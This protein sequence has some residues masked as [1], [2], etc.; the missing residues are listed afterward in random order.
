MQGRPQP[1]F[2]TQ[3]P[4]HNSNHN[5][6]STLFPPQS[7]RHKRKFP[8]SFSGDPQNKTARQARAAR[9]LK[10]AACDWPQLVSVDVRD[11]AA[12]HSLRQR[13]P[14]LIESL[15]A[16]VARF[17][18]LSLQMGRTGSPGS[19]SA[20]CS[21]SFCASVPSDLRS[22]KTDRRSSR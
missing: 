4:R 20:C 16:V 12:G 8:K 17:K 15:H 19:G 13:S 9:N 10:L 3:A 14:R 11:P 5:R 2:L 6:C 21:L 7:Q 1:S 22:A 18:D